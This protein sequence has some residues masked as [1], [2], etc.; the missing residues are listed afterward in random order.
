[1]AKVLRILDVSSVILH[2]RTC[3]QCEVLKHIVWTLLANR[4]RMDSFFPPQPSRHLAWGD[5]AISLM[6]CASSCKGCPRCS[7]LASTEV[8]TTLVPDVPME[9][10]VRNIVPVPFAGRLFLDEVG[11]NKFVL[12]DT[13]TMESAQLDPGFWELAFDDEGVEA[14][15]TYIDPLFLDGEPH[16]VDVEDVMTKEVYVH[17]G[18]ERY[19]HIR[20]K[21]PYSLDLSLCRFTLGSVKLRMGCSNAHVNLKCSIFREPRHVGLR[22]F[23]SVHDFYTALG[24]TSYQGQPS[25]WANKRRPAWISWLE[26]SF[27]GPM[28]IYS[29]R[30]NA[31]NKKWKDVPWH[32]RC[33][34]SMSA[35]TVTALMLL[36]RFAYTGAERGGMKSEGSS[37]TSA[38]MLRS[39]LACC[40]T[41]EPAMAIRVFLKVDWACLAPRPANATGFRGPSAVITMDGEGVL[42]FMDMWKVVQGDRASSISMQWLAILFPHGIQ[43]AKLH[44]DTALQRCFVAKKAL[45]IASQICYAVACALERFWLDTS[46]KKSVWAE[47]EY[48]KFEAAIQ[49]QTHLQRLLAQHVHKGRQVAQNETTM[50]LLTDK[51]S[52]KLLGLQVSNFVFASNVN[53]LATPMVPPS[54]CVVF[55]FV[56]SPYAQ[57][58]FCL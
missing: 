11:Y 18:N 23:F 25:F 14:V 1:M 36:G 27:P 2:A 12:T 19:I 52:V 43:D 38:M 56:C 58:V 6:A 31:D 8:V 35:S 5:Q 10:D 16:V 34:S 41:E 4:K 26:S 51:A 9:A 39:L 17:P 50:A 24:M 46:R 40:Y 54:G 32:C 57:A 37:K 55:E 45:S 15:L 53:I 13:V 47:F 48:E 49:N 21:E 42:D 44:I 30:V 22:V 29:T 7:G 33:V 3:I 28:F 20:G